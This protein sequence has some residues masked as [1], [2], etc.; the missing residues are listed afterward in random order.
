MS[1]HTFSS[2]PASCQCGMHCH[3]AVCFQAQ[4]QTTDAGCQTIH[5][6]RSACGYHLGDM[7]QQ[8]AEVARERGVSNGEVTI[9]AVDSAVPPSP[10]HP[11]DPA[12]MGFPFSTIQLGQPAAA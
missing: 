2:L 5:A 4:L 12:A 10:G 1:C 3:H 6:G 9:M 7:V 8:L 11:G